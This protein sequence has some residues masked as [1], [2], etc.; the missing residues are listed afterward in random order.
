MENEKKLIDEKFKFKLKTYI[1][2]LFIEPWVSQ[3]QMPNLRTVNW[4][5]IILGLWFRWKIVILIT[6]PLAILFHMYGEWK[7]GAHINWYRN[8]HYKK[9]RENEEKETEKISH[10]SID[11]EGVAKVMGDNNLKLTDEG[12]ANDDVTKSQQEV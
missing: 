4:V 9:L 8:Y 2:Y 3:F 10:P 12:I 6:I 11:L 7:S 1:K 5:L